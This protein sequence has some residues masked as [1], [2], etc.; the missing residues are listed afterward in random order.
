MTMAPAAQCRDIQDI[1]PR[2]T[3]Y[4]EE[5]ARCSML[6]L[7]ISTVDVVMAMFEVDEVHGICSDGPMKMRRKV[8]TSPDKIKLNT[9]Q[10]C[11]FPTPHPFQCL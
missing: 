6:V 9:T 10:G 11:G 7:V 5:L 4:N 3:H 1:F 2:T 8:L